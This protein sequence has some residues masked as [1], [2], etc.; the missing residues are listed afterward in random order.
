MPRHV[1]RNGPLII[2]AL[3]AG[4]GGADAGQEPGAPGSSSL[5]PAPGAGDEAPGGGS[6]LLGGRAGVPAARVPTSAFRPGGAVFGLPEPAPVSPVT[7]PPRT[8]LP[9]YGRLSLP[10]A[11]MEEGPPN[12]LTLDAAIQRLVCANLQLRSQYLEIPQA[13]ADVLTAGLRANPL[14]SAD[15]QQ[16]PFGRFSEQRPGGPTQYDVYLTYPLDLN[17]KRRVRIDVA[18]RAQKVLEAQYQDA[19]RQQVAGLSAAF[20][21]VLAARETVRYAR[22]TI[23]G[24]DQLEEVIR[25][26]RKEGEATEAD[27]NRARIQRDAAVIGLTEAEEA[28]RE[29]K[30]ALAPVLNLAAAQAEALEVRGTVRDPAPPPPPA[31]DLVR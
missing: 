11:A 13:R 5:G 23:Q 27:L 31:E 25:T 24:L 6:G 19:V 30:R 12:G 7:E 26:L 9:V 18:C 16:V 22:A 2:L 14:L 4:P 3:L 20:V 1:L 29:A 8:E 15:V 17:H 10:E 21:D 28:L